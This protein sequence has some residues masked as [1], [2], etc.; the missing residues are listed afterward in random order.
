MI[1]AKSLK[2]HQVG[3]QHAFSVLI[4]FALVLSAFLIIAPFIATAAQSET[5]TL[6]MYF[7]HTRESATITFKKNGRYVQSGLRKANRFLRDWRRKEPTRMDPALL[8]LVWEVYQKSGSRKP[9]HVI[10][11]YRSPRTNKLLRRRGRNVA[12]K[13]QHTLG[14]ALDFFMPDVSVS[15]LRALGLQAHRGGVGYYRGSFV[16]LDTGRVR[17]WPRMSQRQLARVFPRGKTIHVPSNGRPLKGFKVAQANLRR[18][19]NADGTKR[20]T[21]VRRSLLAQIFS[22]G[23]STRADEEE[24]NFAK[25]AR[26]A[27]KKPAPNKPV[28]VA[29]A[30]PAKPKKPSGPDPFS[31]ENSVADKQRK[32][33]EELKAKEAEKAKALAEAEAAQKETEIATFVPER[34]PVPRARPA[35]DPVG[36][37][38]LVALAPKENSLTP[39]DATQLALATPATPT[40]PVQRP[41][42]PV[43]NEVPSEVPAENLE[44]A[45][46]PVA[47]VQPR[48]SEEDIKA[49]KDRITVA[50]AR[51]RALS[52]AEVAANRLGSEKIVAALKKLPIP[53]SAVRESNQIQLASLPG[54]VPSPSLKP[55]TAENGVKTQPTEI[56]QPAD[57]VKPTWRSKPVAKA[58]TDKV[59]SLVVPVPAAKPTLENPAPSVIAISTG[60][61]QPMKS[62]LSLGDLDGASV[63]TWAVAV[64]TRVGLSATLTPPNYK[65]STKRVAPNAVYSTGFAFGKSPLRSDRFSGRALTRV[66]FARVDRRQ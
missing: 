25:R 10:S 65:K 24:G 62:E 8:D 64:S 47:S 35:A 53:K 18:G 32:R 21:K 58:A 66:A 51:G 27:V 39:I 41:V 38:Q 16:H 42:V 14:K 12:R 1:L 57:A 3:E 5:R 13:S 2:N 59:P 33:D 63:K 40:P 6:R 48:Q 60:A 29:K 15:K 44:P 20:T 26:Q 46:N 7:T 22:D 30:V 31:L 52:P 49:L 56:T 43:P 34:V 19:L 17:H 37:P 9:I 45:Q 55:V 54:A 61:P 28:A 36:E 4:K 11:G 23:G 50:L